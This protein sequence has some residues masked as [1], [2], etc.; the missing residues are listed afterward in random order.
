ML[1]LKL[2]NASKRAP[3]I[4]YSLRSEKY[5]IG[6]L[7]YTYIIVLFPNRHTIQRSDT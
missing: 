1:G 7:R 3:D 6:K 4:H 5:N 2:T